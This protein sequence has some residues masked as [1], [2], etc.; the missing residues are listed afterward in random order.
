MKLSIKIYQD[1]L[2]RLITLSRN[3]FLDK[4]LKKF[5]MGQ[6]KKVVLTCISE[7][8]IKLISGREQGLN[9]IK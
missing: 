9:E 8:T 2:M 6:V 3:T 5:R 7:R 4:I 1:R